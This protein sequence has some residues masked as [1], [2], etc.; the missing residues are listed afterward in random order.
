MKEVYG[1]SSPFC[2]W[3]KIPF[4]PDRHGAADLMGQLQRRPG[5]IDAKTPAGEHA[6]VDIGVQLGKTI[7]KFELF[8]V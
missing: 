4:Q 7:G 3:M 1:Y 5:R 6:T 2:E 8:R